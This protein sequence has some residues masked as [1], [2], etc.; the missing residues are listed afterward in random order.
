VAIEIGMDAAGD[1]RI[2]ADPPLASPADTTAAAAASHP[3]AEP[4]PATATG[5]PTASA[6]MSAAKA[7]A[8][9]AAGAPNAGGGGAISP[10]AADISGLW[11]DPATGDASAPLLAAARA[12]AAL[13]LGMPCSS[14]ICVACEQSG[15]RHTGPCMTIAVSAASLH[16]PIN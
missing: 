10:A 3:A 12:T 15:C 8:S 4:A 14:C 13:Q 11:L 2:V 6:A 5:Q 7:P 16:A 1:I 9:A